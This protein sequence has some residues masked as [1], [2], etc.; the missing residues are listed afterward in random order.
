MRYES[1]NPRIIEL[2][3][4]LMDYVKKNNLKPSTYLENAPQHIKDMAAELRELDRAEHLEMMK[5]A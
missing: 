3:N 1:K 5:Y 2:T 4:Y